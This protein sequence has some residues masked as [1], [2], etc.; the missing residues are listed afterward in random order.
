MTDTRPPC[1]TTAAYQKHQR[2]GEEPCDLCRDA[3][4]E[5]NRKR[6]RGHNPSPFAQPV[7]RGVCDVCGGPAGKGKAICSERCRLDRKRD[8]ARERN[9][10][11]QMETHTCLVCQTVWQR[12]ATAGKV[13]LFCSRRCGFK[14]RDDRRKARQRNAFVAPVSRLDVFARDGWRCQ[15]CRKRVK[16][17][18][19][20][21]DPL[22][23]TID[24]II[25]L[26]KGG[27]HEPVNVQLACFMC[28]SKKGDRAANDQLRLIG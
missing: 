17:L 26:A 12:Q 6:D 24:H 15:L 8:R 27:T 10:F 13:P 7:R 20:P 11:Q 25:P 16:R 3:A 18:A 2:E 1:G 22:A 28:N 4:L 9:G 19:S 23:P 21:P 5:K 14:V